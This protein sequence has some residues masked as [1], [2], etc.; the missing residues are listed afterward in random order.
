MSVPP[1]GDEAAIRT[2]LHRYAHAVDT[3]RW[4]LLEQVFAADATVDYTAASG[5]RGPAGDLP[6]WLAETIGRVPV[7]QHHLSNVRVTVSGDRAESTCY[8]HNPLAD[9]DGRV[10]LVIGGVYVDDWRRTG[11]GWRITHRVHRP[12]WHRGDAPAGM[13]FGPPGPERQDPDGRGPDGPD[14][15]G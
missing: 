13:A 2:V 9:A 15:A 11:D 7:R 6:G 8:L 10:F 1:P 5:P 12:T 3:G 14:A 4:G